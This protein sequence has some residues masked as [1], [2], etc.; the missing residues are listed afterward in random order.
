VE[1]HPALVPAGA[2]LRDDAA[3]ISKFAICFAVRHDFVANG[4]AI[5]TSNGIDWLQHLPA[6]LTLCN[7]KARSISIPAHR[8]APRYRRCVSVDGL[9][10]MIITEFGVG[11]VTAVR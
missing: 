5:S 9:H 8:Y 1:L 11:G 7:C 4:E 10:E 2:D 6:S 3:P